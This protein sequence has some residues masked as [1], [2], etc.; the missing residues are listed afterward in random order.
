MFDAETWSR[1]P[2]HF[3]TATFFMFG[4]IVG[5]FLNVCIHRM[6]RNE[7]IVSPPSHCP[8]CNYSIPWY[9]NIPLVTWLYLQG[10]CANCRAPISA[11]YFLVE[12][13]TGVLFAACW[14][15]F[16]HVSALLA[17]VYCLFVG[18]LIVATFIDF[19]HYI[20]PDEIT[21]GGMIVGLFC[22]LFVP[23]LHFRLPDFVRETSFA[24]G[25][26]SSVIGLAAGAGIIYAILRGGKLLIGRYRIHFE[27]GARIYFTESSLKLPEED[28]LWENIFYRKS[29]EVL[30]EAEQV[31]LVDRCYAKA[32]LR[33][34]PES[35]KIDEE[36]FDPEKV[37][38]LEAVTQCVV[39]P[40]EVMGLGD[41]KFMGAIG[42]FLGWPAVVFCLGMSAI[43]GLSGAL[44]GIALGRREWSNRVQYGPYIAMAAV[45]WV[46]GGYHWLKALFPVQ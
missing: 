31:E 42:A 45:V 26:K 12:L 9:L 22:S 46:F 39:L 6:P 33:L 15:M 5:S 10:K 34:K 16:G 43:F 8:H 40:R 28:L 14:V 4:C 1:V 23:M 7:S 38:H 18:G 30:L 35:L 19:E 17:L 11:R 13:L 41:V 44:T 21:I 32:S 3:W 20:I 29:D 24:E 37:P 36:E 27:P 25:V 2:F